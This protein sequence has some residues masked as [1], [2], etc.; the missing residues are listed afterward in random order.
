MR[1]KGKVHSASLMHCRAVINTGLTKVGK[2]NGSKFNCLKNHDGAV[3][4]ERAIRQN[5]VC[6][7][8]SPYL[9]VRG[10]PDLCIGFVRLLLCHRPR[11]LQI[12]EQP[13][14]EGNA[15]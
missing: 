6:F 2:S 8:A 11:L 9:S 13:T 12:I 10:A 4:P 5:G 1:Q 7:L 14:Q 15:H 3:S